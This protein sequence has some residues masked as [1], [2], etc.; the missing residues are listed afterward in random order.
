MA[1]KHG[2]AAA[3]SVSANLLTAYC[4]NISL[5]RDRDT[6]ETTVFGIADKTHIQGLLSGS[7]SV[8][9]NYDPTASTGPAAVLETALT[10]AAAVA[11]IYYPGGNSS[12]QR[13]HSFSGIV[14]NYAETSGVGDKVTFSAS[15]LVTGAVTTAT[16]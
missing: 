8:S 2:S 12:G 9:G 13:S 11:C 7:L 3:I 6:A 5:T 15:I 4:D 16:I 1:F 14:T 10:G